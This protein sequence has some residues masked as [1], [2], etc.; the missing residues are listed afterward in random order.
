[1]LGKNN[2]CFDGITVGK[3]VGT[4]FGCVVGEKDGISLGLQIG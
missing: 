2:G 1:V 3:I 4:E